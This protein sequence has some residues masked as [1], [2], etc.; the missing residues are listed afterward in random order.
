[1]EQIRDACGVGLL[2]DIQG[3][4]S[5]AILARALEALRNLAHRG[6]VDADGKTGDGAGVLT[7]IPRFILGEFD[8]AGLVFG[9]DRQAIV[10]SLAR[11][12]LTR[13]AWRDV[14]TNAQTLGP[15][16]MRCRRALRSS[17]ASRV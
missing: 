1:M 3:R 5:R 13:T 15:K 11:K 9:G 6:A 17:T 4:P 12:G 10:D 7:Q 2:A 16:A 14:P 8:A